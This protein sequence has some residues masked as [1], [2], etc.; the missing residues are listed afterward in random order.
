MIT[1]YCQ[2]QKLLGLPEALLIPADLH[3]CERMGWLD[4]TLHSPASRQIDADTIRHSNVRE[5]GS[6]WICYQ[7]LE[8]PGISKVLAEAGFTGEQIQLAVTQIVSREVY[9]ASS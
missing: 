3:T 1:S 5:I 6:E 8:E 7:T 2:F 9:P 4:L